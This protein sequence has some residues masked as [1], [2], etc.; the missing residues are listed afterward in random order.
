MRLSGLSE[1]TYL[2]ALLSSKWE[3]VGCRRGEGQRV[4]RKLM[5]VSRIKL[6][7]LIQLSKGSLVERRQKV[8]HLEMVEYHEQAEKWFFVTIAQCWVKPFALHPLAKGAHFL[9]PLPYP[10][11]CLIHCGS[12]IS[13]C[14]M[15]ERTVIGYPL[16]T[17][18]CLLSGTSM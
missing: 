5:M 13:I 11:W 16:S 3:L 7:S 1:E 6:L 15:N 2:N 12:S 9:C 4:K 10:P 8:H 14:W 17:G 18:T